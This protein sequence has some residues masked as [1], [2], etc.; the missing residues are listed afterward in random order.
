MPRS[1]QSSQ[2]AKGRLEWPSMN[3]GQPRAA[4][5]PGRGEQIVGVRHAEPC[6]S[7]MGRKPVCGG[8]V[9]LAVRLRARATLGPVMSTST[10]RKTARRWARGVGAT[11]VVVVVVSAALAIGVTE[12]HK[13]QHLV[14]HG[15]VGTG[16][17]VSSGS[18]RNAHWADVQLTTVRGQTAVVHVTPVDGDTDR[19]VGA[20]IQVLYAPADPSVV[21]DVHDGAA[22]RDRWFCIAFGGVRAHGD[23]AGH[24]VAPRPAQ[25]PGAACS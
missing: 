24:A 3:T 5:G 15:V 6:P 16:V 14:E 12:Q 4:A 21:A 10:W 25:A 23:S 1:A 2:L 17:V 11:A 7:L 9:P 18:H 22:A 20:P 13:H 8:A 19:S